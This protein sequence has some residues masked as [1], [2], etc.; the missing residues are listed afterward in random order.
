MVWTMGLSAAPLFMCFAYFI[1]NLLF[2]LSLNGRIA[3]QAPMLLRMIYLV[4]ATLLIFPTTV[5]VHLAAATVSMAI[6]TGL[7]LL[8]AALAFQFHPRR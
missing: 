8:I 5:E 3:T 2:I 6:G 1:G 7:A 4:A